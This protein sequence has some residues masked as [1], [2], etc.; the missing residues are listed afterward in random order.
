LEGYLTSFPSR[1]GKGT[2]LT[3]NL[4][5]R[6]GREGWL[7][8]SGKLQITVEQLSQTLAAGER[9]ALLVRPRRP[10]NFQNPGGFDYE[11]YFMTKGIVAIATAKDDGY[12]VPLGG[13]NRL[14]WFVRIL[15]WRESLARLCERTV[16]APGSELMRT[17]ILGEMEALTPSVKEVFQQTGTGHLLNVSGLNMGQV[18]F[19]TYYLIL[20]LLK[21]S[22]RLILKINV[23]KWAFIG[24]IPPLLFYTLLSGLSLPA[25]RAAI[26][27]LSFIVAFLASRQG[28]SMSIL[29]L[30]ALA[31]LFIDPMAP[32]EIS[33]Q[34]S[35]VAVAGIL[36]AAPQLMKLPLEGAK[37]SCV[38]L[39]RKLYAGIII[40]I[41]AYAAT[42]PF[43]VHY[44]NRISLIAVLTNLWAVPLVGFWVVPIGLASAL[45]FPISS[46]L[47]TLG[48]QAA[49]WPLTF[50]VKGLAWFG[51]WPL[52]SIYLFTLNWLE[53]GLYIS[54]FFFLFNRKRIPY[55]T[56]LLALT[57]AV[58]I[59]DTAYWVHKRVGH[60]DLMV[61]FLDVGQGNAALVQFPRGI[62][63]VIDGGG[64]VKSDFDTGR[65]I[66]APY[67]WS[68]KIIKVDYIVCTHPDPDHVN[69]LLFLAETF[70]PR[71]IWSTGEENP[72]TRYA[73]LMKL[74]ETKSINHLV[75]KDLQK[76]RFIVGVEVQVLYPPIDFLDRKHHE[77]FRTFNNNSMVIRIKYSQTTFLFPADL[78]REGEQELVSMTKDL[79]CDV[80]LSTHHGSITSNTSE[81]LK[82]CNPRIVVISV[83][84]NN[85]WGLPHHHVLDLYQNLGCKVYRT[86]LHG[87]V[88]IT[89]EGKNLSAQ[90]W[91]QP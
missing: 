3:I 6:L 70:H 13:E 10:R 31:I 16:P 24:S 85:W 57:L 84:R 54:F 43:I 81:F 2:R 72:D 14:G 55:A 86:D 22:T 51:S 76:N 64:F 29:A 74:V 65:M 5:K 27:V 68:N 73:Q 80:L 1:L 28:D 34:L 37:H 82:I 41:V 30:S 47:T 19:G 89:S 56:T 40:S 4:E 83:G 77:Q 46:D 52:A 21:R 79:S 90:T 66:V 35:F 53:V 17:F 61:T 88:T 69:G 63:M 15:R 33:F 32:R 87:A 59:I 45:V 58:G 23:F 50:L 71:E 67:L 8:A 9:V 62:N 25:A 42:L 18:A 75:L 11:A 36:Y 12:I 38:R 20:L 48:F 49:A 44:F 39:L 78:E 60:R 91:Q 7:T 26:M